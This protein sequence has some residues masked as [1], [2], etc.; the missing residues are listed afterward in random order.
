M[1]YRVKL[2]LTISLLIAL[3]L[4]IGGTILITV[5]F[6]VSLDAETDAA[7]RSYES[8][9]STLYLLNSMVSQTDYESLSTALSQMAEQ[10]MGN[11]QA[12]ILRSDSQVIYESRGEA[13]A[14]AQLSLSDTVQCCYS[15][16]DDLYGHGLVVLSRI[17]AGEEQLTLS[18][19]FDMSQVYNAR[20]TQLRLYTVVYIIVVLFGTGAAA[21]LSFA[22]TRRLHRLTVAVRKI[23]GGDLSTRS[24][25]SSPDEFGQLSRDFDAMADKLQENISRMETE[26]QRQESFMG[27]FAH[28][29]KTPMTSI[30]GFADLL[31]QGNLDENTRIMAADYIYSEGKRLEKLSFKLLDLILL[32]KDAIVMRRVWLASY[33]AE[34]ERALAPSLKKKGIRLVCKAEQK[35]VALEPDLVKSLLY[36]LIDNAGKAM[37]GEGI[38]AVMATAIP[39][40]C[41]FQV[42]D[43]GRGMEKE[44]LTKITEA[45]Y[46]VDKSRSR[47][48][49]GAGLGLALCKQIVELHNGSIHFDSQPSKGTRITVTLYGKEEKRV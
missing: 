33:V 37:D 36:N 48:Q 21:V 16:V 24:K 29:L 6:Q 28:E 3:S 49:G 20:Q 42:A 31:R 4:S 27:A 10:N 23:S 43:N 12:L 17:T 18:A 39:G 32:K 14:V 15:L 45:F 1:S 8:V 22:M 26:M 9:Q 11:W 19:R 25:L 35:R 34:I 41:Q 7:L 46:R 2:I 13:L 30:I 38:I 44:E 47:K 40:G 5:S